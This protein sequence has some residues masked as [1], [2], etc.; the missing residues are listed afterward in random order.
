MKYFQKRIDE[1][2]QD[3]KFLKRKKQVVM[4]GNDWDEKLKIIWNSEGFKKF[5]HVVEDIVIPE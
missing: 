2:E 4:I 3:K 5:Y 1:K